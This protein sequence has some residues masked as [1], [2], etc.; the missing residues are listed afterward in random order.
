[1]AFLTDLATNITAHDMAVII[2]SGNDDSLVPHFGSQSR[3]PSQSL[4]L[5]LANV[6]I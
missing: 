1:M 5:Q 3:F 6:R 2:Y 4:S